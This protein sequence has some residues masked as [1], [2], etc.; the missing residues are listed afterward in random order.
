MTD[1]CCGTCIHFERDRIKTSTGKMNP[2]KKVACL[3]E[4]PPYVFP[5]SVPYWTQRR[6]IR[7]AT[8]NVSA[9]EG[10]NCK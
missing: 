2:Y 6:I 8:G 4:P 7:T 5:D 1:H 3:W 9:L 10:K